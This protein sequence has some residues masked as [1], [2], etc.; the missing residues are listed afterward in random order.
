VVENCAV[1]FEGVCKDCNAT[2]DGEYFVE[3]GSC[4]VKQCPSQ[5]CPNGF[6]LEGC[7]RNGFRGNCMKCN[8]P[9]NHYNLGCRDGSPADCKS[10]DD[11]PGSDE[12][13]KSSYDSSCPQSTGKAKKAVVDTETLIVAIS[14][15]VVAI[16]IISAIVVPLLLK[17]MGKHG[18]QQWLH[19]ITCGT[20]GSNEMGD[21]ENER[22]RVEAELRREAER[23]L[24][25]ELAMEEAANK[26]FIGI[27]CGVE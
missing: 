24:K 12:V 21:F 16:M 4:D 20:L 6:Y 14:L 19:K 2:D 17:Y 25:K 18:V 9:A 22:S 27:D 13:G 1:D 11:I 5:T 7:G 3:E 8:C 23:E 15:S 10:C 26:A